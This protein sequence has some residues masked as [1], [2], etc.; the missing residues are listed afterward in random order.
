MA[1]EMAVAPQVPSW[2]F[3]DTKTTI[4]DGIA[5]QPE[6]ASVSEI[7]STTSTSRDNYRSI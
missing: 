5:D 2:F 4:N 3:I 1:A 6:S 7:I